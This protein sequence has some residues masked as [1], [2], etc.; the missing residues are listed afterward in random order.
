MDAGCSWLV[1][2]ILHDGWLTPGYPH[3]QEPVLTSLEIKPPTWQELGGARLMEMASAAGAFDLVLLLEV[4]CL[5]GPYKLKGPYVSVADSLELL[6]AQ[7]QAGAFDEMIVSVS[8]SLHA[9]LKDRTKAM[10]RLRPA[11]LPAP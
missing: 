7:V 8:A 5:I 3:P 4:C 10:L 9:C 11:T 2:T 1:T 6:R